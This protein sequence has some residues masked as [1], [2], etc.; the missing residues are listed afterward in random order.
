[1]NSLM[2]GFGRCDFT[3]DGPVPQNGSRTGVTVKDR[4]YATC[5]AWR[6]EEKTVLQY[7]M[8]LR[9]I[10]NPQYD[11]IAPQIAEQVGIP[12]ENI[13]LTMT[14]NHSAPDVGMLAHNPLIRDWL[15]RI[16]LPAM[17]GAGKA[18]LE[19]L[20]PVKSAEYGKIVTK[21][22]G[23]VR[24]YFRTDGTHAG[25]VGQKSTAPLDRAETQADPELR[26]VRVLREGKKDVALINFQ[27]HAASGL[28]THPD[29]IHADFVGSLRNVV[30]AEGDVLSIYLQGAC[31]NVNCNARLPEDKIDWPDDCFKIGEA[32]GGYVK[33]ALMQTKPLSLG[34]ICFKNEA[35]ICQV[36]H[37]KT[38]LAP[39]AKTIRDEKDPE[40]KAAMMEEAGITSRYELS[41]ILKRS[42]FGK[43]REMPLSS[44]TIG[45]LAMG[46]APVELFDTCGKEFRDAAAYPVS[47]FCGYTNGSHSYMPS[48]LAFP[49]GGYEVMECHY[50][51]GTGERIALKLAAMVNEDRLEK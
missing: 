45:D 28:G 37:A 12:Q 6:D 19:D 33:E 30:E 8:D 51:P 31:G 49:N 42:A 35:L 9:N 13:L 50:V 25:I 36:N 5:L 46:F 10:Y 29:L 38:H 15:E 17:I 24:R 7:S 2:L 26:V 23:F 32:M 16:G 11:I 39:I 47:F 43:T 48:A 40:K 44:L 21:K 20:S 14:H 34:K 18:A 27:T 3:P 1:M 4:L 22:L 41:A